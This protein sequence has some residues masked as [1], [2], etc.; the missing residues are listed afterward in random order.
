MSA[1]KLSRLA[2]FALVL[3]AVFGGVGVAGAAQAA[4]AAP[5]SV[6]VSDASMQTLG[7]IIWA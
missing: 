1:R 6:A 4:V 3:A 7:D 2:G 5:A